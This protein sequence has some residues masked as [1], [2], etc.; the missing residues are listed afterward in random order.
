MGVEEKKVRKKETEGCPGPH[1][2][3]V[4]SPRG[5]ARRRPRE[6]VTSTVKKTGI[7]LEVRVPHLKTKQ[8]ELLESERMYKRVV[9]RRMYA[10]KK[11]LILKSVKSPAHRA[12][13]LNA[14]L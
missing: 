7:P 12:D 4:G 2:A 1:L 11:E 6:S 9:L 3:G 5:R 14:H 10:K 13:L 8:A